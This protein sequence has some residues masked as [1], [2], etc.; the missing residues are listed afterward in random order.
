VGIGR[1]GDDALVL[2]PRRRRP[3]QKRGHGICRLFVPGTV[4][5]APD[6]LVCG[7]RVAP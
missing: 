1:R 6:W 7:P 2:V 5:A 3:V 4:V